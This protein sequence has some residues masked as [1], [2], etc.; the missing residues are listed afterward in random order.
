MINEQNGA[1]RLYKRFYL[2][3]EGKPQL[4][5][6]YVLFADLLG[7]SQRILESS[8]E[9]GLELLQ[10]VT[11]ALSAANQHIADEEGFT[12]IVRYFSDCVSMVTPASDSGQDSAYESSFGFTIADVVMWQL[13]ITRRGF[14]V[15]GAISFGEVYLDRLS[16]FGKAHL[17]AYKLETTKAKWP[18]II[19][20]KSVIDLAAKQMEAYSD[21]SET[22]HEATLLVDEDGEVFVNY[23][24]AVTLQDEENSSFAEYALR[25]HQYIIQ[26][27]MSAPEFEAVRPKY[28]WMRHYHNWYCRE[29][30]L[31]FDT[32]LYQIAE[33]GKTFGNFRQWVKAR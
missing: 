22:P 23:L 16:L 12:S 20:D 33:S 24:A 32:S 25:Q 18:R 13:E 4:H 1:E 6:S 30:S 27:H 15:R 2:T 5:P 14:P 9:G 3:D 31:N 7:T 26:S 11:E 19:L 10:E 29:A 28:E 8:A 17:Q 21:T